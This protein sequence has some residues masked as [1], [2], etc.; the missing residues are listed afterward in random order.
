MT[1]IDGFVIPV[2]TENREAYLDM[3]K[4]VAQVFLDHGALRV[5]ET[6]ADDIQSGKTNDFRTAV[7]AK[8][9]EQVVFSWIEW[10]SREAR[11]LGN[12][13]CMSDPRMHFEGKH[14]FSGER[15]I[16]GGFNSILD[17]SANI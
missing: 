14:P 13:K 8:E 6:W 5:V 15:L 10:P 16:Y 4:L 7:L 3:A 9:D 12:K 11:D 17:V 2:P 1:Y